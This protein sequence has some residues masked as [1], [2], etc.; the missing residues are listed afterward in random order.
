MK[1]KSILDAGFVYVQSAQTDIRQTFQRERDRLEARAAER[2][3]RR[4]Q[5]RNEAAESQ[6][7]QA[8]IDEA[9]RIEAEAKV[10]QIA[11][12]RMARKVAGDAELWYCIAVIAVMLIGALVF[13]SYRCSSR[14]AMSGLSTSWGPMQGCLVKMPDGRWIP[15]DRVRDI[16]IAP[17]KV[18]K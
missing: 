15:D 8:E 16:D 3:A 12:G 4:T 7:R 1:R 6:R 17:K 13:S 11:Q 14:W 2:A 9:N 18:E 5:K 10:A